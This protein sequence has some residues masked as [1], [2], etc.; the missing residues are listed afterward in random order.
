MMSTPIKI[1]LKILLFPIRLVLLVLI[2]LLFPL[3]YV[4]GV[5]LAIAETILILIGV[6]ALITKEY[7][8]VGV[9]FGLAFLA[10]IIPQLLAELVIPMLIKAKDLLSEITE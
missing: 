10:F 2:A 1:L 8:G 4:T 5:L 3:T 7:L 9:F 6:L